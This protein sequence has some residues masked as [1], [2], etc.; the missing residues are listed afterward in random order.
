MPLTNATI[1]ALLNLAVLGG[2]PFLLYFTYQKRRHKRT[3][4]EVAQRAGLQWGDS[5]YVGY[6]LLAAVGT[7]AAL[8]LWP[9][10]LEPFLRE[11]SPQRE[12]VGLGLGEKAVAMAL[13]YGVVKT[14]FT[15][16]LL[17]RGLIAGSLSRRLP[18][19]WANLLQALIFLA[20]HLLVLRVM[21]EMWSIIPIIFVGALFAGWVRIKSG[22][23]MG[24]WMIH[25]AA[26]VTMCL[27]VAARTSSY[28]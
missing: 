12:F 18:G 25:A 1:S 21:P 24:P 9:P 22:S 7:V 16:E 14:G 2:L 23:I 20:P 3:F 5:R 17:F 19:V 4:R 26:N 6:S 8:I 15:E 13:L 10:P 28:Q 11:G 27:S